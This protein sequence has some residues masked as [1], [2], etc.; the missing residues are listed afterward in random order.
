[1]TTPAPPTPPGG[2]PR[3]PPRQRAQTLHDLQ[4]A[5]QE[6]A[7]D[8]LVPTEDAV[9]RRAILKRQ[10]RAERKFT[11][12]TVGQTLLLAAI[13]KGP[14][15]VAW[16]DDNKHAAGGL[17]G[18]AGILFGGYLLATRFRST[19]EPPPPPPSSGGPR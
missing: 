11:R 12:Y 2:A 7:A 3:P 1:V 15:L 13:F 18:L 9:E 5:S 14:E 6:I 10:G 4:A 17:V 16:A 8:G 19:L